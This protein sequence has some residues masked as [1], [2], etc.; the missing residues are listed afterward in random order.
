MSVNLIGDFY[1]GEGMNTDKPKSRSILRTIFFYWLSY[2]LISTVLLFFARKEEPYND[3][4]PVEVATATVVLLVLFAGV[5]AL[6]KRRKP[7]I[8]RFT[9]PQ[10]SRVVRRRLGDSCPEYLQS[11]TDL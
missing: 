11:V 2:V 9:P 4:L 7:L 1:L 8:D 10:K 6:F 3:N 5:S